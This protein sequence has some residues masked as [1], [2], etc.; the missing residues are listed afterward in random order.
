MSATL[1]AFLKTKRENLVLPYG[2]RLSCRAMAKA[3]GCSV[4]VLWAIEN[5]KG[6]PSFQLAIKIAEAYQT[7]LD[8]MAKAVP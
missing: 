5:N 7:T 2:V 3:I 1:G 8:E 4:T 6:N